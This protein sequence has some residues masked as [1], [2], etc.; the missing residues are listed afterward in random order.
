MPIK[1][2]ADRLRGEIEQFGNPPKFPDA[3]EVEQQ[4]AAAA[5]STGDPT[6]FKA[7]K[8]KAAAKKGKG[9][10]QWDILKSSGIPESEIHLFQCAAVPLTREHTDICSA[11]GASLH[12]VHVTIHMTIPLWSSLQGQ[13][14]GLYY[15][16]IFFRISHVPYGT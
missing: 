8:G 2:C 9:T 5:A 3:S 13:F 10:T 16:Y 4:Q 7:T 11:D 6:V 15:I 1:A 14:L 12:P